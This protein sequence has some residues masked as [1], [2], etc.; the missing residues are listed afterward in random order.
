MD[1]QRVLEDLFQGPQ[2]AQD[3]VGGHGTTCIAHEDVKQFGFGRGKGHRPPVY[4]R[5]LAGEIHRQIVIDLY[6]PKD[7]V[8]KVNQ[9]LPKV[10]LA[11]VNADGPGSELADQS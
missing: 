3:E 8:E 6:R 1:T 11:P 2:A 10:G 9:R 5:L 7:F 4:D